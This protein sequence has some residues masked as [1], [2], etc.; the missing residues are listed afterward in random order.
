MIG[1]VNDSICFVSQGPSIVVFQYVYASTLASASLCACTGCFKLNSGASAAFTLILDIHVRIDLGTRLAQPVVCDARWSSAM[2]SRRR[3]RRDQFCAEETRR[4]R[5]PGFFAKRRLVA[6]CAA[7]SHQLLL[8]GRICGPSRSGS[9]R[10]ISTALFST[11]RAALHRTPSPKLV[12]ICFLIQILLN[13]SGNLLQL[14]AHIC[15][16]A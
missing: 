8:F 16:H 12:I 7:W 10:V 14:I 4:P 11:W 2:P 5:P 9:V 15:F 3:E 13:F 1:F 6:G